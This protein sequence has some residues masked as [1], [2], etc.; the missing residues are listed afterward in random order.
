MYIVNPFRKKGMKASDLSST[1][2]PISERIRILRAM[3]GVSFGDYDQAY[4]QV[5]QGGKGI[6][7]LVAAGAAPVEKVIP[8]DKVEEPD[9]I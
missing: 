6:I 7:P 3:S 2:P 4:R 8:Q 1:H 5:H 9:W